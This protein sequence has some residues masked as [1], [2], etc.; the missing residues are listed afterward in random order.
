MGRG[1]SMLWVTAYVWG[2]GGPH[3][4]VMEL[5]LHTPC[6]SLLLLLPSPAPPPPKPSP[7]HPQAGCA[8]WF[9]ARQEQL[10]GYSSWLTAINEGDKSGM[11]I[12]GLSVWEQY[13]YSGGCG[14]GGGE[15]VLCVWVVVLGGRREVSPPKYGRCL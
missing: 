9:I 5:G 3:C 12:E 7:Q 13:T 2:C 6:C 14:G 10:L 8:F 11:G 4:P 15:E 1:S